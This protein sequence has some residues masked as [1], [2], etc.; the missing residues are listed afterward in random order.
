MARRCRSM[1]QATRPR[2]GGRG[3]G[4]ACRGWTSP[5]TSVCSIRLI[6]QDQPGVRPHAAAD[7][8]ARHGHQGGGLR[9][10]RRR[11]RQHDRQAR[12]RR[13]GPARPAGGGDPHHGASRRRSIFPSP[14][15]PCPPS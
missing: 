1:V 14:G 2:F 13:P 4:A 8:A 6:T 11:R 5:P 9:V 10:H 15:R 3:A 12:L 7:R